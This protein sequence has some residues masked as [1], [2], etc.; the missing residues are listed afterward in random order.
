[1]EIRNVTAEQL[2]HAAHKAVVRMVQGGAWGARH[3]MVEPIGATREG[4]R[5]W[6]I[7][8]RTVMGEDGRPVWGRLGFRRRKDGTRC[9]V[10][11]AVCW[12]GHRAFMR[13]LLEVAPH[14]V[15]VTGMARYDGREHFEHAHWA[16]AERN[17]GSV[18]DPVYY[19]DLCDCEAEG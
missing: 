16:T 8:L 10:P 2:E 19:A 9:R 4:G 17:L 15:I 3:G 13:A 1:M 14:A 6:R 5:K 11:G 7:T 18:V 12:H